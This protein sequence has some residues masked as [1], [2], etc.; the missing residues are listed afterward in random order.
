MIVLLVSVLVAIAVLIVVAVLLWPK[1]SKPP[2]GHDTPDTPDT[3][4]EP[5]PDINDDFNGAKASTTFFS[6][7]SS[8][9]CVCDGVAATQAL[10]KIGWVGA[11]APD[12]LLTPFLDRKGQPANGNAT[13]EAE[14]GKQFYSNCGIGTG[15]CGSCWELTTTGD[16]NIDGG[17][18]AAG[19]KANVVV[20]DACEDRNAYGNNIQWCMAAKGVPP[21]GINTHGSSN[22]SDYSKWLRPGIF[23]TS[24]P[25]VVRWTQPD[26]T[27]TDGK[28]SCTNL[29][30]QPL[31][32]DIAMGSL[33]DETIKRLGI[34]KKGENPIVKV[35][36][37]QCPAEVTAA[38]R[39]HCG[40]NAA[41]GNDR[42]FWCPQNP[43]ANQ[44]G[45]GALPSQMPNWW[46]GCDKDKQKPEC[47]RMYSQ[48]G[49]IGYSG[50]TCCQWPEQ[51]ECRK[52]DD[53]YS[54]CQQKP[55]T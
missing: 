44:G 48:C 7:G 21:G 8:T 14:K 17:K 47:A 12:W 26:C 11:A 34:W 30:G 24:D 37:V 22:P 20:V 19:T 52:K 29:A 5:G 33:S 43:Q 2:S 51:F 55:Q 46:G 18:V 31:H 13:P 16:A 15:G 53:H 6:F 27:S 35:K 42:C 50:P 40:A 3:P 4:V 41:D 49:G 38:L 25:K 28:F 36:K 1:G 39:Q 54:A 9:A 10:A 45:S 23:D 32:F